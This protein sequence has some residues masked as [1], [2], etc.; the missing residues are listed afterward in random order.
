MSAAAPKDGAPAQA[1]SGAAAAAFVVKSH[2]P[3]K[4]GRP[5][6][7]RKLRKT[8]PQDPE[9]Y[10]ESTAIL[11]NAA[12]VLPAMLA[13]PPRLDAA[14][15]GPT[16]LDERAIL[17]Y[18]LEHPAAPAERVAKDLRTT[19]ER[20]TAVVNSERGRDYMSSEL[21][22]AGATVAKAC[23]ALAEALDA[24]HVRHY[25]NYGKV[26]DT[27]RDPDH[28]TRLKAAESTLSLRGLLTESGVPGSGESPLAALAKAILAER[29]RRGLEIEPERKVNGVVDV[30]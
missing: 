13:P 26:V 1:P 5:P 14:P 29:Q 20:V 11:P 23:R 30:G 19:P 28:D 25:A 4:R 22:A 24:D 21:D 7:G 15:A 2:P 16:P 18:Q 27:K 6:G 10:P 3:R 17:D 12:D 8:L 9:A